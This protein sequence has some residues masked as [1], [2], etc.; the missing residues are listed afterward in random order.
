VPAVWSGAGLTQLRLWT[1]DLFAAIVTVITL[2][3]SLGV[4]RAA[5]VVV[6]LRRPVSAG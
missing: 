3:V 6:S 5:L 2:A 4:V 1:P